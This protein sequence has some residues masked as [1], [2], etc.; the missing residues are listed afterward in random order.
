MTRRARSQEEGSEGEAAAAAPDAGKKRLEDM[1]IDEF[2]NVGVVDGG[3][4]SGE[5]RGGDEGTGKTATTTTT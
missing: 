5:R 1:S 3:D 2:L 4:D